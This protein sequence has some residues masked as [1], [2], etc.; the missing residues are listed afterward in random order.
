MEVPR[1][2][3]KSGLQLPAFT[4]AT[5]TPDLNRVCDL[6]H[7]S[8]QCRILNPLSEA[9]DGAP[10]LM[11]TS[12]VL[13]PL[14]HNGNSLESVSGSPTSSRQ[15]PPGH[16]FL[17]AAAHPS[18]GEALDGAL[19]LSG[20]AGVLPGLPSFWGDGWRTHRAGSDGAEVSPRAEGASDK[21]MAPS[22]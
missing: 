19:E 22:G 17:Q 12:W 6:H 14:S 21:D 13:N 20:E 8:R 18:T 3:V 11:D 9:R 7:S 5:A 2:G 10:I 15:D 16:T 1:L 4:T